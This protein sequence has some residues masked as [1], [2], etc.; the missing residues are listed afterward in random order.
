MDAHDV[1]S[2]DMPGLHWSMDSVQ[3]PRF[4]YAATSALVVVLIMMLRGLRLTIEA[5]TVAE[6]VIALHLQGAIFIIVRARLTYIIP[7]GL[8]FLA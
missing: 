1:V 6:V 2:G 4:F 3:I 5:L 8:G 7:H